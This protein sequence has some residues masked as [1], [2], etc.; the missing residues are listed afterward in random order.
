MFCENKERNFRCWELKSRV[1][2]E[3]KYPKKASQPQYRSR[4]L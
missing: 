1:Y 2:K 4:G 3:S